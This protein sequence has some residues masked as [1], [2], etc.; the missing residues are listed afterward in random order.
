MSG[1]PFVI[2]HA[3]GPSLKSFRHQHTIA[4]GRDPKTSYQCLGRLT[5]PV[6][7]F[8]YK[9]GVQV[10]IGHFWT[11]STKGPSLGNQSRFRRRRCFYEHRA[12]NLETLPSAI[13]W[14]R[15]RLYKPYRHLTAWWL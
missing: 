7:L 14:V 9:S 6:E 8:V 4:I 12:P 1:D 13:R 3:T 10:L 5:H 2:A 15:G 11:R